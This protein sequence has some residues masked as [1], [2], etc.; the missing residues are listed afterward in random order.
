MP[1]RAVNYQHTMLWLLH[2]LSPSTTCDSG[3][4]RFPIL[5]LGGT[6]SK[7][8]MDTI[9][10][11]PTSIK[12]GCFVFSINLKGCIFPD[13]CPSG[14]KTLPLICTGQKDSSV[15]GSVL[16]LSTT[17]WFFTWVLMVASTWFHQWG[18]CL[19]HYL[20]NWLIVV[21]SL[22]CLLQHSP[23]IYMKSNLKPKFWA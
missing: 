1:S 17:A 16:W 19:H 20:D 18:S 22:P 3:T 13:P 23:F 14:I 6:S 5:R 10:S 12:N 2:S 9:A 11:V 7:F 15:Q 8:K 21:N 4:C